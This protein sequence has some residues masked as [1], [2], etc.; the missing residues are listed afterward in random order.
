MITQPRRQAEA[1]QALAAELGMKAVEAHQPLGES[2]AGLRGAAGMSG[3]LK[4][5]GARWDARNR[6]LVFDTWSHLATAL[7]TIR[8]E[9][10]SPI[11][12]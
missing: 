12:S 4:A 2:R 1:V 8:T 9:R 10:T 6:A 3:R 5:L 7:N 11:S